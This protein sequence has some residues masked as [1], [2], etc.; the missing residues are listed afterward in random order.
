MN[1][2]S[3]TR[4]VLRCVRWIKTCHFLRQFES[5]QKLFAKNQIRASHIVKIL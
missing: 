3:L 1:I 5:P 2:K 4:N